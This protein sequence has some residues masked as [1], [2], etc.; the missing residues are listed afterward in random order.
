MKKRI[1]NANIG[2][3]LTIIGASHLAVCRKTIMIC[4]IKVHRTVLFVYYASLLEES[5]MMH[6]IKIEKNIYSL[7]IVRR[8]K[9]FNPIFALLIFLNGLYCG[10]EAIKINKA[11]IVRALF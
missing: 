2:L 3:K 4:P 6:L 9:A 8:S 7:P 10:N 1:I 11:L 5:G